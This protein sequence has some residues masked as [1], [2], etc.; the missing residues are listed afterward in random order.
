MPVVRVQAFAF[1]QVFAEAGTCGCRLEQFVTVQNVEPIFVNATA[2]AYAEACISTIPLTT[3][4]KRVF[5]EAFLTLT[6]VACTPEERMFNTS[7]DGTAQPFHTL[8]E[9]WTWISHVNTGRP[10]H[11]E[12]GIVLPRFLITQSADHACTRIHCTESRAR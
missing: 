2:R 10:Q 5:A 4:P 9:P 7:C 8:F 3:Y 1:V 12:H 6:A 11:S